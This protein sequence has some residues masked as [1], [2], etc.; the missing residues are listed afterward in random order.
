VRRVAI[1]FILMLTACLFA[2]R[3][4]PETKPGTKAQNTLTGKWQEVATDTKGHTLAQFE[5]F[6][7]GTVVENQKILGKWNQLGAGSF[8][9]MDASHLKV[10]LQP[11]WYFGIVIYQLSWENQDQLTLKAADKTIQLDRVLPD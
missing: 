4:H 10:E 6:G 9:F 11:S 3:S 2:C 1:P 7:D 5:F 8:K